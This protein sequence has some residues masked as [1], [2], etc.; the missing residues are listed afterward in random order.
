M[1]SCILLLSAFVGILCA[2]APTA[3]SVDLLV[4]RMFHQGDTNKDGIY[5]KA[6]AWAKLLTMDMDG[7]SKISLDEYIARWNAEAPNMRTVAA[8]IFRNLDSDRSGFIEQDDVNRAYVVIDVDSNGQ[9]SSSEF[10]TYFKRILS[11][12]TSPES[13]VDTSFPQI[14]VNN[15]GV[16]SFDEE[17]A[18]VKRYDIN[19]DD[20]VSKVEFM[21]VISNTSYGSFGLDETWPD[22]FDAVDFDANRFL[23]KPEVQKFYQLMDSDHNNAVTK[24]EVLAAFKNFNQLS[25]SSNVTSSDQVDYGFAEADTNHDGVLTLSEEWAHILLEDKN[26]DNMV[27][28][29]EFLKMFKIFPDDVISAARRIF[30]KYDNNSDGLFQKEDVA[31]YFTAMDANGDGKVSRNVYVTFIEVMFAKEGADIRATAQNIAQ[32]TVSIDYGFRHL[33][34][35]N[36]SRLSIDEQWASALS[37]DKNGDQLLSKDEYLFW[38]ANFSAQERALGLQI[39]HRLDFNKNGF[40]DKSDIERA[41]NLTDS[42][43]D[44]YLS[45][46]EYVR[47]AA[48]LFA[49]FGTRVDNLATK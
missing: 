1:Y 26:N 8:G 35:N 15:D 7:N 34:T 13:F 14:D 31:T 38:F 48:K 24:A 16:I 9:V 6:E 45:H 28:K 37:L 12:A 25:G 44:G 39:F 11:S 20:K 19:G 2:L 23:E 32:V 18:S 3:P 49:S 21:L 17:W 4:Q 22:M 42:S 41:F 30:D 46:D 10:V 47:F 5:T 36:D 29:T 40:W 33:D 27:D 43:G